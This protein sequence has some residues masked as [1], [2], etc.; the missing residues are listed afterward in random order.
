MARV[1][2][3]ILISVLSLTRPFDRFFEYSLAENQTRLVDLV[4]E[5]FDADI[6]SNFSLEKM[7]NERFY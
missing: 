3:S 4:N 5:Y 6:S 1:S 2:S 7:A